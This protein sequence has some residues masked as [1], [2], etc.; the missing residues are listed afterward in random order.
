MKIGRAFASVVA[1]A[2][3]AGMG[4]VLLFS[5]QS[6][7]AEA[8]NPSAPTGLSARASWI[9]RRVGD[10]ITLRWTST[11]PAPGRAGITTSPCA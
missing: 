5:T 11:S 3:V 7:P 10:G 6:R 4:M 2:V 8:N 9:P 1:M